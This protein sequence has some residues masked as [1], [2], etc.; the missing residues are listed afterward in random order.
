MLRSERDVPLLL[1][2]QA[3]LELKSF[4]ALNQQLNPAE[5][6]AKVGSQQSPKPLDCLV[7][8]AAG[9]HSGISQQTGGEGGKGSQGH[10]V[11]SA[12]H[13]RCNWAAFLPGGDLFRRL[14]IQGVM[15]ETEAQFYCAELAVA[16]QSLHRA[17]YA[18]RD[19]KLANIA[20][21]KRGHLRL[22]DL[23]LAR[24][25]ASRPPNHYKTSAGGGAAAAP[26]PNGAAV[27]KSSSSVN[28]AGQ[29]SCG[30]LAPASSL[31]LPSVS[32]PDLGS[33]S[34]R[35]PKHNV[36]GSAGR[37]DNADSADTPDRSTP[38]LN[39]HHHHHQQQQ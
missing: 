39:H 24:R 28:L 21:D 1:E 15:A 38:N 27:A 19:I 2:H 36:A 12:A 22:L 20:L 13:F 11:S 35:R 26:V 8:A 33:V 37:A 23:A 14:Q 30:G 16:V 31:L 4:Q 25:M 34:G 3:A 29:N 6:E 7:E 9:L 32:Y 18:H 17:G 10:C 5:I